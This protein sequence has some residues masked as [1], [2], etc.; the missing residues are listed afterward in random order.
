MANFVEESNTD[1]FFIM[2]GAAGT[3]KTSI[4]SALI[5]YL[6]A[7][8]TKYTI[9]APTGRA[10]RILGRK[11]GSVSNTIHSLIY[12]PETNKE[13][14]SVKFAL[15]NNRSIE[16]GI[17]IID[18][19]SMV[20]AKSSK[21]S[22][23]IFQTADS[24][25]N[26][27]VK[28]V[29]NG[30]EKNKIIFLGDRNQLPPIHEKDA[31]ALDPN[32]LRNKFNLKGNFHY[33]TEVKRQEEGSYI[34]KDATSIRKAIDSNQASHQPLQAFKHRNGFE[35]ARQY[36]GNYDSNDVDQRVAIGI[37]HKAN[38]VFNKEVRKR[39]FS[40]SA[41]LVQKGDLMLVVQNWR[42]GDQVLYN[43]DHVIVEEV[44]LHQME[45][46]AGLHFAPVKIKC[47]A[48]DGAEQIIED[49]MLLE[50]L[51]GE[52]PDIDSTS[53]NRL[54]AERFRKNKQFS[55][56]GF[57]ADDRYVGALRLAYGYAITCHKAQ[58]GE[59]NKVYVNTFG[60]KDPRWTYTA[61]TRAKS[62]LELY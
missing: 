31:L 24:V 50:V 23:A 8:S 42:R 29:K 9:A 13:T 32:Y 17:Y 52:S 11:T 39:L 40:A 62:V 41:P 20:S 55:D 16:F 56:S 37:S 4:T 57:P 1:D 54:R 25:L 45:E 36:A 28:F 35:A 19:A 30:N 10:A 7:K 2:C 22:N 53:E 46:V 49:Y 34:L 15:K 44:N 18:E 58:G 38:N 47:K 27:L 51:L 26:D 48:L 5:G 60:V 59:W 6:N 43:G 61:I 14:G 33:L 12:K 3:G 21:G